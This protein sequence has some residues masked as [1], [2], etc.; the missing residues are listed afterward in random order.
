MRGVSQTNSLP[1]RGACRGKVR[2]QEQ[3][4]LEAS[5]G[6]GVGGSGSSGCREQGQ[7]WEEEA[8]H[9]GAQG[10][11]S[12][13]ETTGDC[14]SASASTAMSI[15]LYLSSASPALTIAHLLLPTPH[16]H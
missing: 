15:C 2:K 5:V 10:V 8:G 16:S 4:G 11:V 9:R 1:G 13:E 6:A 7:P 12:R 3:P 14:L